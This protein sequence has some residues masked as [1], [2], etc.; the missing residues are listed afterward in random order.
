MALGGGRRR[1]EDA[2]DPAVGLS[3][4]ACLD[5]PVGPERPLALVHARDEAGAAA[6][7]TAV[8]QA[9]SVESGEEKPRALIYARIAPA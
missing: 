9:M 2:I 6:A 7:A 1:P 4:V 5:E 8:R 3:D